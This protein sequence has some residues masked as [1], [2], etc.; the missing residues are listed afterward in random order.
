MVV[1]G[2]DDLGI[3]AA[4]SFVAASIPVMGWLKRAGPRIDVAPKHMDSL[5]IGGSESAK[6]Q[7]YGELMKPE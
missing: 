4:I 1:R 6:P 2:K 5:E 3:D 7:A